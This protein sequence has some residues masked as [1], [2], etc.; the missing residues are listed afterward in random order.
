MIRLNREDQLLLEE[1]YLDVISEGWKSKAVGAAAGLGLLG[2]IPIP[3]NKE[4]AQDE[5]GN[6]RISNVDIH[7][8]FKDT[9]NIKRLI[10]TYFKS[11]GKE[12]GVNING[13]VITIRSDK[14]SKTLNISTLK[15]AV[16]TAKENGDSSKLS[17]YLAQNL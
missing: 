11:Q 8:S 3:Y 1:L 16:D 4:S 10:T 12:V 14:G 7:D 15:L 9:N 13:D 2:L 6:T 17:G 5:K